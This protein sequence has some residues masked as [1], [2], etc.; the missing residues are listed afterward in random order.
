MKEMTSIQKIALD[1]YR[2]DREVRHPGSSLPQSIWQLSSASRQYWTM[3]AFV[4]V[5]AVTQHRSKAP[6]KAVACTSEQRFTVDSSSWV[7]MDYTVKCSLPEGHPQWHE[8]HNG[9]GTVM[10]VW[11]GEGEHYRDYG[12]LTDEQRAQFS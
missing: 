12:A 6:E 8:H 3:M 9:E 2:A 4:A 10:F 11:I 5:A 1:L 7:P